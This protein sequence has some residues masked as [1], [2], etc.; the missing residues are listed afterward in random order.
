MS[1]D[2]ISLEVQSRDV[3]GKAVKHLRKDGLVPAVIH[4][5]GKASLSV[6]GDYGTMLKTYQKAGRHHPVELTANG[7][8]FTTLIKT[9]TFEPK[10]NTLTHIVFNAVGRNE[11]VD[12]VVPLRA[13]YD[14]ENESSP[15]ERASLLVLTHTDSVTVEA[16]PANLPDFIEY[17]A[18]KLVEVG[19]SITV[20]DLIVPAKVTIMTDPETS[21]ASVY[22]PS[23]IAAANDAAGGDAEAGDEDSVESEH[24]STAEEGTQADEIRPGGK[25]EFE[26][27]DQGRDP[28]KQ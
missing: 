16:T 14:E 5:H 9:A 25:K 4:D 19:D 23:A 15:A 1:Q 28:Q 20:A 12:A 8:K 7:K 18:E 21:V 2:I 27:N 10:K 26:G 22:E 24:E 17:D 11:T 6:M 13:R 3:L